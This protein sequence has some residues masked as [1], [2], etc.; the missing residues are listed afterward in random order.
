MIKGIIFD[1][2]LCVFNTHSIRKTIAEPIS[3]AIRKDNDGS[4]LDGVT[5]DKVERELW[6]M[7]L[8]DVIRINNIPKNIADK[9]RAAYMT[10]EAPDGSRNYDD[11]GCIK[12]LD[13]V[14]ILV[15]SGYRNFQLSKI[16]KTG[17]E[18][19]F[20]EIIVDAIDD[21][22]AIK[23]KQKIFAEIAD[24]YGWRNNEVLVVG[25]SPTSELAAG[26]ALD[27]ITAQILRPGV[28]KA[29]GFDYYI[30]N[31]AELDGIIKNYA[32]NRIN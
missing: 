19:C 27:M 24:K 5:V 22:A 16:R 26:K 28:I 23:G 25:D 20:D 11:V 10:L 2:D 18:S 13:L 14:K 31:L 8:E 32:P 6:L 3:A 12:R 4:S 7:G 30:E 21:P 17:I 1:L 15:T 9:M 29:D